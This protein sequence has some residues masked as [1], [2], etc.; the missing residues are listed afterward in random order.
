MKDDV[1]RSFLL[2]LSV[3]NWQHISLVA[4][5][6]IVT[7]ISVTVAGSLYLKSKVLLPFRVTVSYMIIIIFTGHSFLFGSL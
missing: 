6:H 3:T 5:G 4:L 7:P 1:F 2:A